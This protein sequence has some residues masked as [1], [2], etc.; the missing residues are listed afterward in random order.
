MATSVSGQS[1]IV[2]GGFSSNSANGSISVS[3]GQ[4]VDKYLTGDEVA[5]QA[6]VQQPL[7]ATE[8]N[9]NG[10]VVSTTDP[11]FNL[12]IGDGEPNIINLNLTGNEGLGRF[13]IA[14]ATTLDIL[15]GN[16][17][18]LFNMENYPPGSYF[19]GH[20]SYD[21]PEFFQ[22][23]GNVDQFEG[24]YDIS[25]LISVS[26]YLV[27]GGD[28]STQ[29]SL[30]VCV[31]DGAASTISFEVENN[32]GPNFIW[33]LL[34]QN[35]SEVVRSNVSGT[36]RL[37]NLDPGIYKVVHAAY[38][39][40]INIGQVDPQDITGCVA[41]SNTLTIQLL[42]CGSINLETYP[43]PTTEFSELTVKSTLN[44]N[45]RIELLDIAGRSLALIYEGE[46]SPD[47]T[48]KFM[49]SVQEF[50]DGLYFYKITLP[51][52]IITKKF[53]VNR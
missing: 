42:D 46:L 50:A 25:N 8:C 5:V 13:G 18:G 41:T 44:S 12:C 45:V 28:I 16:G 14:D 47:N 32:F 17:S 21:E 2:S 3:L 24:C 39:L 48:Q 11:R 33:A 4:V 34:D 37:E 51:N 20:V 15:G 31:N 7:Y 30:I 36:F 27:D 6:G 23:I 1:A 9:V 35:F 49:T 40:G 19:L 38:G 52:R 10:G 43:N 29:D 53:L 22:G 26:S